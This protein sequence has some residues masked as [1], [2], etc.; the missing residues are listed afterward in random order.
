MTT[1]VACPRAI[2]PRRTA[3]RDERFLGNC[4]RTAYFGLQ[5]QEAFSS[6]GLSRTRIAG[7]LPVRAQKTRQN[8]MQIWGSDP[9]TLRFWRTVR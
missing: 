7:W 3:G 9:P 6:E 4:P 5:G 2:A 1:E 8:K